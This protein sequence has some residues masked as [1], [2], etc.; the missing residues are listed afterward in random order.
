[1]NTE[2]FIASGILELYVYGALPE[3]ENRVITRHLKQYPEIRTEVEE[4]E[5]ALM[6]LSGAVAP[7]NPEHLLQSIKEKLSA[8]ALAEPPIRKRSN[9]FAY[10][11]WAASIILLVGLFF[12]FNQNRKLEE[13]LQETR[14]RNMQLEIRIADARNDVE[15]TRKLLDVLRDRNILKVPLEGQQA[16]PEAYAAA[17]WDKEKNVTYIDAL[18]LPDPPKGMVYQIWSLKMD[19][20]TPT[21][22]G[23]LDDFETDENKIF[24]LSNANVS[25]GFGITLEPEGGSETPT[26]ERLYTLG[27]VS[28]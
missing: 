12:L 24:E 14:N 22:M 28:S 16:A 6:E 26:L 17:Y 10:T 19:P 8:R 5:Q 21:S 25:E 2:E 27:V 18:G 3:T 23:L 15:K 20:L 13:S 7:E 9:W 4:I 11:G 1:M